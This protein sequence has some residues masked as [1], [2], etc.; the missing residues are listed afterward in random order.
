MTSL[1]SIGDLITNGLKDIQKTWKPTLKYTVWFFLAPLL[2]VIFTWISLLATGLGGAQPGMGLFGL[3]ILG[4]IALILGLVWASIALM[5][6]VIGHAQGH[7][8]GKRKPEKP[9]LSYLPSLLWVTIL[10]TLP[11][12]AAWIIAYLPLFFARDSNAAGILL[13]VLFLAALVFTIWIGVSF[14]QS[15]LLV[16]TDEARGVAAIK[17]SYALVRGRWWKTLWRILVPNLA[18]QLIVWTILSLFYGAIFMIGFALFGG[19]LASLGI[20]QEA[21]AEAARAANVGFGLLGILFGF[22]ILLAGMLLFAAQII[23]QA[24]YQASVAARLFFSLRSTKA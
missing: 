17:R 8:M 16:L 13:A 9:A 23:A 2:F 22:L 10:A 3:F 6:H 18:F 21:G 1:I 19:W 20:G 14:S 4:Y 7:D 5:Q 12:V 11:A 15:Y 24:I